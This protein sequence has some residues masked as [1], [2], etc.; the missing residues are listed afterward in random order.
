[1]G[2]MEVNYEET[3]NLFDKAGK[4]FGIESMFEFTKGLGWLSKGM[5]K[6]QWIAEQQGYFITR[7]EGIKMPKL[8]IY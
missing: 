7:G 6:Q 5:T 2:I 3:F 8:G 1:M 4:I